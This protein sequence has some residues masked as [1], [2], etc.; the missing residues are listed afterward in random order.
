[1]TNIEDLK[2]QYAQK[3]ERAHTEHANQLNQELERLRSKLS[4]RSRPVDPAELDTRVRGI[5]SA[6]IQQRL[7]SP[8]NLQVNLTHSN[9]LQTL[10]RAFFRLFQLADYYPTEKLAY[11]TV[12]CETLEEFYTPFLASM[13]YSEKVRAA[14]LAQ[15][16]DEARTAADRDKGGIFG[17]NFPGLGCY[18]NGWLFGHLAGINPLDYETNPAVFERVLSTTT[19][20]KLGHGFISMYSAL[21]ELKT[22]L[23]LSLLQI[24]SQF[25]IKP[26]D[27]A[28]S[29]LK[30][31]QKNLLFE[32]S[33]FLEEG[34]A[35]WIEEYLPGKYLNKIT[36]RLDR[37]GNL[38]TAIH[39]LPNDIDNKKELEEFLL[40]SLDI[41]L[42]DKE[43]PMEILLNATNFMAV[44]GDQFDEHFSQMLHQPLRY[45]LGELLC[46]KCEQNLGALCVPYA[47]LIAG[48]ITFDPTKIGFKDLETLL[49]KDPRLNPDARLVAISKIK[50]SS[51][52]SVSELADKIQSELSLSI[53]PELRK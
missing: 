28:S 31:E 18:I 43:L 26:A 41:L 38:V 22:S 14:C 33:Q 7:S 42:N 47:A 40:I 46:N 21:G 37:S 27:D 50:L 29:K 23:G 34:W 2:K 51:R 36:P 52:G 3:L 13:D 24:A 45:V 16:I 10:D 32:V 53:P 39:N 4:G 5:S 17:V 11:P 8:V 25:G 19:H 15:L 48:N 6:I 44:V 35:T 30:F 20:E 9:T 1:M 12:Y 49:F